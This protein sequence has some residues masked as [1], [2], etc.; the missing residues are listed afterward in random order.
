MIFC[1]NCL[2][3]IF[4]LLYQFLC[5]PWRKSLSWSETWSGSDFA[6][7]PCFQLRA[8]AEIP[9]SPKVKRGLLPISFHPQHPVFAPLNTRNRNVPASSRKLLPYSHL[10]QPMLCSSI[11]FIHLALPASPPPSSSSTYSSK[12]LLYRPDPPSLS[13]K[14]ST[15][16]LSLILLPPLIYWYRLPFFA[17]AIALK[18]FYFPT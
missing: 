2:E 15:G 13:T 7:I 10:V 8:E 16:S 3:N 1:I 9:S 5:L 14:Q 18:A 6:A 12:P 4:W 17:S 11:R